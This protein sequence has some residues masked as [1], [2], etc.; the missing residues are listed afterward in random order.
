MS[1]RHE[2]YGVNEVWLGNTDK[3]T[4]K[5]EAMKAKGLRTIRLGTR[6]YNIDGKL[7]PPFYRPVFI[8]RAEE[9]AYSQIMHQMGSAR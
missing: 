6:A 7:L 4:A 2:P 9:D 1:G 5:I 8:A 3:G